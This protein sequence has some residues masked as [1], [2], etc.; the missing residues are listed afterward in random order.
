MWVCQ[1]LGAYEQVPRVRH[2]D[3]AQKGLSG[4]II[5]AYGS[6]GRNFLGIIQSRIRPARNTRIASYSHS[7]NFADLCGYRRFVP[8]S[9]GSQF[10]H[11]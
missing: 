9:Q 3:K 8:V 10:V 6:F 4:P 11:H 1:I 5:W 7:D 2:K